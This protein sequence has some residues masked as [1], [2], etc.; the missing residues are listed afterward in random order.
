MHR[1]RTP[2]IWGR[3]VRS[4]PRR[5]YLRGKGGQLS[6]GPPGPRD[7]CP[8]VKHA[9]HCHSRRCVR[10]QSDTSRSAWRD[11]EVFRHHTGGEGS[12]KLGWTAAALWVIRKRINRDVGI[13]RSPRD[14]TL[15]RQRARKIILLFS[16]HGDGGVEGDQFAALPTSVD[17]FSSEAAVP[18][19]HSMVYWRVPLP[20]STGWHSIGTPSASHS[21]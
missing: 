3:G 5:R 18:G 13:P 19:P 4:S 2:S 6:E 9:E 7:C 8:G 20:E 14:P 17:W 10:S 15:T 12:P 11:G 16:F 21:R 1:G